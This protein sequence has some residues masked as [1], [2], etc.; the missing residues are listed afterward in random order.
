MV[1]GTN[2]YGFKVIRTQPLPELN[3]VRDKPEVEA[4]GEVPYPMS[5]LLIASVSMDTL[6]STAE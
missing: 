1:T 4:R 2:A 6:R 3:A 5:A